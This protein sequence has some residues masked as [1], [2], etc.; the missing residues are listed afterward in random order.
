MSDSEHVLEFDRVTVLPDEHLTT[1]GLREVTFALRAGEVATVQVEEGRENVPL[2][3]TAEGLIVADEGRVTFLGEAWESM[4]AHRQANRR[5]LVRRVFHHYGWVSNLS[6]LDNICLAEFHHTH[7]RSGEVIEEAQ[8]LARR[9]GL[10]GIADARPSR[11]SGLV[12]RKLEWVRALLGRP[13]LVL[14]ERPLFGAPR[15]DAPLLIAAVAE[16]AR[17]GAAV[18]WLTDEP[19][20]CGC[21]D[22]ESCKRF[23]MEG[24]RLLPLAAEGA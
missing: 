1:G 17:R 5:G 6:I 4:S 15:A 2:A 13:A 19:R 22:F 8:A 9:F 21:R 14:L 10:D 18:L 7:R 23:R 16:E 11:V 3:D 12:L 24:E 20:V